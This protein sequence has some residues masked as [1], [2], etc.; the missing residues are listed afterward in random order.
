MVNIMADKPG[1]DRRASKEGGSAAER[2]AARQNDEG[3][4]LR[5]EM[6]SINSRLDELKKLMHEHTEER[7][8]LTQRKEE[9]RAQIPAKE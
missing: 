8:R 7:R 9:L 2:R 1:A 3:K 4:A 6:R 5:Q